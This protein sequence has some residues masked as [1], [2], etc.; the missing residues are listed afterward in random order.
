M[1]NIEYD[2]VNIIGRGRG[3]VCLY[4]G[5]YATLHSSASRKR[6]DLKISLSC[7]IASAFAPRQ[8]LATLRY[9]QSVLSLTR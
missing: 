1:S 7:F 5:R 2:L 6:F 8:Y 4:G 9:A 3:L